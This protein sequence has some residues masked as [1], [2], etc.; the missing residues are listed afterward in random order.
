MPEMLKPTSAIMG[1]GLG[2]DVALITDGRFSGVSTGACIGHISPEAWA[3]G[4]IGKL[5][6]GDLI[7]IGPGGDEPALV[8][9]LEAEQPGLI[10][11]EVEPTGQATLALD[12]PPAPEPG[13]EPAAND[14][15]P[16]P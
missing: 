10:D 13:T 12:T 6:D 1:A 2:K 11:A 5:R 14:T 7:R 4:P 15:A 9:R 8:E 3:G 16:S